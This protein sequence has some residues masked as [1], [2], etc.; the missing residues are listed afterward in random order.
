MKTTKEIHC[1]CCKEGIYAEI[2]TSYETTVADDVKVL[3]PRITLLRCPKCGDEL[4]P[5]D[6]QKQI[7][8]AVVEQTE[9]LSQRDLEDFADIF[10]ED[11]KHISEILGLGSKTFHRW[12]NGSQF[13]SR[14]MGFYL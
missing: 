8:Q 4:I 10:A 13:P 5:P 3:I 2:P 6:A 12:I 14:S 9:Q 1:L 11:Q 7:D